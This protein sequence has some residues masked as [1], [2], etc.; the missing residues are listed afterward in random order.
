MC[1]RI[2]LKFASALIVMA[3]VLFSSGLLGCSDSEKSA[4]PPSDSL[5]G[6]NYEIFTVSSEGTGRPYFADSAVSYRSLYPEAAKPTPTEQKR[7]IQ[8]DG[9]QYEMNYSGTIESRISTYTHEYETSDEK[10]SCLYWAEDMQLAR[11]TICMELADFADMDQQQ[12]EQWIQSFVAQFV[13]ED[14]SKYQMSCQTTYTKAVDGFLTEPK[15]G[16]SVQRYDFRYVR[17]IDSVKTTDDIWVCFQFDAE[18]GVVEVL[19]WF[20]RHEFDDIETLKIDQTAIEAAISEFLIQHAK[21]GITLDSWN[22]LEGGELIV[23]DGNVLLTHSVY[24]EYK[25]NGL[26]NSKTSKLMIDIPDP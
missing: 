11:I 17:Y 10:L 14:W 26:T 25:W 6:N 1:R 21:E 4:I 15:D 16:E 20:S 12:Y 19:V 22:M 5:S 3:L 18:A 13:Q 9:V 7:I 24:M 23:I 2:T 8:I